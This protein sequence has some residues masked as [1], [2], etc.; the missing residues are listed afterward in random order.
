MNAD[1]KLLGPAAESAGAAELAGAAAMPA[2]ARARWVSS[3]AS[4]SSRSRAACRAVRAPRQLRLRRPHG[5]LDLVPHAGSRL[6]SRGGP[7]ARLT[8]ARGCLPCAG[9]HARADAGFARAH[10]RARADAKGSRKLPF[11]ER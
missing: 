5:G 6:L 2:A 7:H 1:L 11:S 4:A 8:A 10:A 3:S 9:L